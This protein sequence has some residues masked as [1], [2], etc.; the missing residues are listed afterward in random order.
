MVSI[1]ICE[2]PVLVPQAAMMPY[3]VCGVLDTG[4]R[5]GSRTLN[6][7]RAGGEVGD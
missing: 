1:K 4:E 2:Y 5:A 3:G 7:E 6:A